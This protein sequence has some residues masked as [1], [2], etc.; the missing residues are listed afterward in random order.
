[1]DDDERQRL[2]D[3]MKSSIRAAG[4]PQLEELK[5][6]QEPKQ[7]HLHETKRPLSGEYAYW[8]DQCNTWIA[9]GE[10][11]PSGPCCP[12]VAAFARQDLSNR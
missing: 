9:L 2:L 10:P 5:A 8:C 6:D 3:E 1:M 11:L 4:N 7:H 12:T